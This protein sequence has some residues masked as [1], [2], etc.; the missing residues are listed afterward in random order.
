MQTRFAKI[1]SSIR[2]F[3]EREIHVFFNGVDKNSGIVREEETHLDLILSRGSYKNLR[4]VLNILR[5][6]L[7][8]RAITVYLEWPR[9][10]WMGR[11][12]SGFTSGRL[13]ILPN[14]YPGMN[15]VI[16]WP[17]R[18]DSKPSKLG[19]SYE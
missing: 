2:G 1:I 7:E 4:H 11:L 19:E 14:Q 15:F 17:R 6:H 3:K 8:N 10:S 12:L 5:A 18:G 13:M 16:A 9:F